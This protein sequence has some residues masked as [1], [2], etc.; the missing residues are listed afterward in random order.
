MDGLFPPQLK[1]FVYLNDVDDN[2]DGP[3]TIVPGTQRW[4]FR[5]FLRCGERVD[6][7][8]RR[9]MRRFVPEG[10]RTVLAQRAP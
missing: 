7:G 3:Y 5:K 9:Y 1:A 10:V 4:F 2:G 8:C 6:H